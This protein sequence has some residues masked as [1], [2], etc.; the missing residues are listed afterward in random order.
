[1]DKQKYAVF[2]K[3]KE[4]LNL[5]YNMKKLWGHYTTSN[6]PVTKWKILQKIHV[7]VVQRVVR[8]MKTEVSCKGI[9]ARTNWE[10]L[11]H[12]D[13]FNTYQWSIP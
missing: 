9:W 3:R 8:I 10:L 4:I 13:D 11:Y 5:Y 7:Y 2:T 1:M 12:R 6:Y